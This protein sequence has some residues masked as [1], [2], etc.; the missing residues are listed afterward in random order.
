MTP[1]TE[2][3][4]LPV[5]SAEPVD[6]TTAGTAIGAGQS[7][8]LGHVDTTDEQQNIPVRVIWWRVTDMRGNSAITNIRVWLTDISYY[9]GADAWYMDIT[10]IWTPGKTTVQVA[11]G[12]PGTAPLA[13]PSPNL[14]KT[15]GGN[16]TGI[17]HDQTSQ[18]IYLTG[19]IGVNETTGVKNGPVLTVTYDYR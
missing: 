16:I 5:T 10:D 6:R 12:S 7:L 13:E 9:V 17:T 18:Y 14:T 15:G 19:T 8:D 4:I 3:R 2:F 11:T 1:E